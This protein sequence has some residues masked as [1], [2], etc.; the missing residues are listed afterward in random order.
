MIVPLKLVHQVLDYRA[1]TLEAFR[2]LGLVGD[3]GGEDESHLP[4]SSVVD[5]P[6]PQRRKS[7]GSGGSSGGGRSGS[8]GP[9]S[10]VGFGLEGDVAFALDVVLDGDETAVDRQAFSK[11]LRVHV[12]KKMLD[13]MQGSDG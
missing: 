6:S 11:A 1:G 7:G 4:A 12:R 9:G 13:A 8:G 10:E 5:P 3:G 2:V